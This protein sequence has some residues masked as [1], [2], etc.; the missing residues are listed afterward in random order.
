MTIEEIKKLVRPHILKLKP[1][2]SA[3]DEYSGQEGIFLDANE[4]ALG[5]VGS[6]Q[7]NRYP[8]PYQTAIKQELASLKGVSS[9][10]IFVGNGSDEAIDLLFRVFCQPQQ[11]ECLILPPTYGMYKVSASINEVRIKEIPLTPNY[12]P[13]VDAILKS[14]SSQT[15]LL[16][17]CSPNNPTGNT[18][19][20]DKVRMLLEYFP[21]L[22]VIDEAYIDFCPEK[23]WVNTLN[24]Y[25]NLV[26]MQTFSKAWGLAGLRVGLAYA[27]PEIIMLFNRIKPPYNVSKIAQE[28]ILEALASPETKERMAKE[29]VDNRQKLKNQLEKHWEVV[30]IYPTEANFL[31]VKVHHPEKLFRFLTEQ[32]VIVRNRSK[33]TLC[34]NALRIT[35]GTQAENH[36]L[37]EA[38]KTF[39]SNERRQSI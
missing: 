15:K 31:L 36:A 39:E 9:K 10:Q 27:H 7:Y 19:D 16:F 5:S 38:L 28:K 4:N 34:E 24:Q 22:V 30:E 18:M 1:Y 25:P 3:R 11:D 35:V 20:P 23:T 33:V 12:Q 14:A 2:S 37:L 13:D 21:G 29:I 26:V 8:D 32:K 17:L 6:S